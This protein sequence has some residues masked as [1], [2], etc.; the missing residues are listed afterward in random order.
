[1]IIEEEYL[2]YRMSSYGYAEFEFLG[3]KMSLP[4]P[5]SSGS[6]LCRGDYGGRRGLARAERL[7][8][9]R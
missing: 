7:P 1:M 3:G 6:A 4:F 8:L 2:S 5:S 9:G